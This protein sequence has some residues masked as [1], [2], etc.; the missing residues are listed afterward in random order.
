MAAG[1]DASGI[2]LSRGHGSN[3]WDADENRFVDLAAGFG[4]AILGHGPSPAH[5]AAKAQADRLVQGLGDLYSTE[6]K[7]ELLER[8]AALLPSKGARAMLCQAGADAVTAALKTAVLATGRPGVIA[9]E[10]SYHGM[11]YAPLAASGL[12][13]GFRAPFAAQLS[14]HV[15]FVSF[16][17]CAAE[18][19]DALAR[20]DAAFAKGDVGCVLIEPILGRGGVHVA[21]SDFLG[22]V[23]RRARAAEA[24]FIADEIWTG[25][26]R[27]GAMVK[28][29][30][31]GVVP[32][33]LCVGKALGAGFPISACIATDEA[34]RG[35]ARGGEVL[36]TS[37]HAGAPLGCAAALATLDAIA[38]RG[39]AERASDLGAKLAA[40]LREEVG[41]HAEVRGEGLLVGVDLRTAA[42]GIAATRQLLCAGYIATAGGTRGEVVVLTPPLVIDEGALLDVAPR[43][44][45]I[46]RS[47]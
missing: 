25:L 20:V 5:D 37:T 3:L 23:A 9:F 12:S 10:G 27:S 31:A 41:E 43:I 6:T 29:V 21:S 14:P 22:E 19:A 38:T 8:L 47:Q 36:H 2:V 13:E 15:R 39:L 33:I 1:V 30:A 46:A 24:L 11:G 44:G 26:G 35:W 17:K 32:D 34:M 40:R 28:S 7:L 45:Q 18:E 4:A 16:P 42:R